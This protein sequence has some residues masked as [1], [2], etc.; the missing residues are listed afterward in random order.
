MRELDLKRYHRRAQEKKRRNWEISPHRRHELKQL[1]DYYH[2]LDIID[3][4]SEIEFDL[5]ISIRRPKISK[6]FP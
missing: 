5:D 1:Q 3:S 2:D 6:K 4:D